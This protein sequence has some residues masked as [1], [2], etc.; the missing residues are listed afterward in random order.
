MK[1]KIGGIIKTIAVSYGSLFS[2]AIPDINNV[3]IIPKEIVSLTHLEDL[4][5]CK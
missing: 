5:I 2:Y 1:I 4:F 3:A